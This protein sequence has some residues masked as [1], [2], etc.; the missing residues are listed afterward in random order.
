[1][2]AV[3]QPE[4]ARLEGSHVLDER[5]ARRLPVGSPPREGAGEH[6]LGERFGRHR[7][8]VVDACL[9]QHDCTVVRRR[10]WCDAVDH[11]GHPGD[12]GVDPCR[13]ARIDE[14]GEVG[15]DACDHRTVVRHVVVGDDGDRTCARGASGDKAGD[16]LA[17]C[18]RHVLARISFQRS[19]V[20]TDIDRL[21]VEPAR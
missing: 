1:V 14:G 20:C 5:G 19:D 8:G 18:R 9:A 7:L 17:W 16:E 2:G 15:D 4:L 13:K 6:P 12:V 21:G 3:E 10:A 11:G